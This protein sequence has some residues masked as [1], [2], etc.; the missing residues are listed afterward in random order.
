MRP[1]H[2]HFRALGLST[3]PTVN[4]TDEKGRPTTIPAIIKWQRYNIARA[5]DKQLGFWENKFTTEDHQIGICMGRGS[6][7]LHVID[8]ET[9]E[10]FNSVIEALHEKRMP[11]WIVLSGGNKGGGHVYFRLPA[12]FALDPFQVK[13]DVTKPDRV[14]LE[15]LSGSK[16]V[17]SPG[18][19]HPAS[20]RE[21]LFIQ[22]G[23]IVRFDHPDQVR[24]LPFLANIQITEERLASE[25]PLI[26]T[27]RAYGI[28]TAQHPE[29]NPFRADTIIV[30][31]AVQNGATFEA[32]RETYLRHGK[33]DTKFFRVL[34]SKGE[35]EATDYL[36]KMFRKFTGRGRSAELEHYANQIGSW[37][38]F[39][40]VSNATR[41][42]S[43]KAVLL[44]MIGMARTPTDSFSASFRDLSLRSGVGLSTVHAAV[45]TILKSGLIRR[46]RRSTLK[47][48]HASQYSL[49]FN[50]HTLWAPIAKTEQ[51]S[52]RGVKGSTVR[53]LQSVDD[54][55]RLGL[56][57][58]AWAVWGALDSE[59]RTAA[60]IAELAH[61]NWRTARDRAQDLAGIGAA[62]QDGKR[63]ARNPDYEL[64]AQTPV[65]RTERRRR[66]YR[67]DRRAHQR[68]LELWADTDKAWSAHSERQRLVES[69]DPE[70]GELGA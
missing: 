20:G 34:Q 10:H 1:A 18:S 24:D 16:W 21:N 47:D 35:D 55:L 4:K 28:L 51:Y 27:T 41:L 5:T 6:R 66:R 56:K 39:P 22:S 15:L 14:T 68:N 33:A 8:C 61:L 49:S 67:A 13:D 40:G 30:G 23:E 11:T 32:L 31:A 45:E 64:P 17:R 25:R 7:G 44:A 60:Q 37:V 54:L 63:Y 48:A 38:S 29:A 26:L 3:I 62:L 19:V 43:V 59:W 58:S 50:Q 65:F 12:E 57:P 36:S 70:T 2:H 46:E 53:V 9:F 42:A 69:M 52:L